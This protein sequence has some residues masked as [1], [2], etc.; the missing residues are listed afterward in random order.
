MHNTHIH[1]THI[2]NRA[3]RKDN[4]VVQATFGTW[5]RTKTKKNKRNT[6]HKRGA[7]RTRSTAGYEAL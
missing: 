1:N 5:F 7:T 3:N 2:H 6:K 4:S